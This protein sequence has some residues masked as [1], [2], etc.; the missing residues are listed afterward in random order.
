MSFKRGSG[1]CAIVLTGLLAAGCGSGASGRSSV[2]G[3]V[4]F[5]GTP[6]EQGVVTLIPTD[7][8]KSPSAG[9]EITKGKF[10][11]P[12]TGGPM[13]GKFRVEITANRKTGKVRDEGSL[14]GKIEVT[15]QYIPA[16]YNKNS[17]LKL[18]VTPGAV[19]QSFALTSK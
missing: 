11:I 1:L 16:K 7:G 8:T 9:A 14:V 17:E 12:E 5:D 10:V 18:E 15:E 3:E 4:T 2:E 19:K 6:L 13:P